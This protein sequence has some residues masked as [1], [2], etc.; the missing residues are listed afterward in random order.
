MMASWETKSNKHSY[1]DVGEAKTYTFFCHQE[2]HLKD[3]ILIW[4]NPGQYIFEVAIQC[5]LPKFYNLHPFIDS[6]PTYQLISVKSCLRCTH[7]LFIYCFN[8]CYVQFH[9]FFIAF[10]HITVHWEEPINK[11]CSLIFW[12]SRHLFTILKT[13]HP[14]TKMLSLIFATFNLTME[15]KIW[16]VCLL[17]FF[18]TCYSMKRTNLKKISSSQNFR[19]FKNPRTVLWHW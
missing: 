10:C 8:I 12:S 14:P 15:M 3:T 9:F 1:T 18:L 6:A 4:W 5:F 13:N 16:M 2:I 7:I 17:E 19:H 11:H